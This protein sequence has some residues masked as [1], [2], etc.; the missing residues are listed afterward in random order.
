MIVFELVSGASDVPLHG[1][2]RPDGEAPS[3]LS[4]LP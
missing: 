3:Q 4:P 1:I 2:G